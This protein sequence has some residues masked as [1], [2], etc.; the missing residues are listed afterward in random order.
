MLVVHVEFFKLL[1]YAFL[2]CIWL[3]VMHDAFGWWI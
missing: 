1:R 2:V 3:A